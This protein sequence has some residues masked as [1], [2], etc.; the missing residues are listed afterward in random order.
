MMT[1]FSSFLLLEQRYNDEYEIPLYR[2]TLY[3]RTI[4]LC[5]TAYSNYRMSESSIASSDS[6]D[7]FLRDHRSQLLDQ[8]QIPEHLLHDLHRQLLLTFGCTENDSY[9][10]ELSTLSVHEQL[11]SK[12]QWANRNSDMHGSL[13]VLPHAVSWDMKRGQD[14]IEALQSS[15]TKVLHMIW[16]GLEQLNAMECDPIILRGASVNF[17]QKTHLVDAV[18]DHPLFWSRIVLYRCVDG[19]VR[20]AM[21][22]PPFLPQLAIS[23]SNASGLV[24]DNID[25][26]CMGPF[27]FRYRHPILNHSIDLSLLYVSRAGIFQ[28]QEALM[29]GKSFLPT[30]DLVPYYQY[31]NDSRLRTVRYAALLHST[32]VLHS[33]TVESHLTEIFATFV[34]QMHLV[35]QQAV[36]SRQRQ[37]HF[38]LGSFDLT[39]GFDPPNAGISTIL[40]VF[41]DSDDP[42]GLNHPIAGLEANS[43]HFRIVHDMDSADVVFSYQSVFS[44]K[45]TYHSYLRN[46]SHILINQFPYEGAFVQKDHLARELL[47]QH[48]LPRPLW[49]LETYDLDV[50]LAEMV[51]S[52]LSTRA[53]VKSISDSSLSSQLPLWIVKP[54]LGTQSHGH[55]VTR[56]LAHILHLN[57]AMG[58]RRV[59]QWYV[60]HPL[61][62]NGHKIDARIVVLMTSAGELDENGERI[63]M[64]TLFMHKVC[65]F[66][67]AS[68]PH[69]ISTPSSRS[70]YE[71]VLTASHLIDGK[72]RTTADALRK[73][74]THVDTIRKLE[75][76]YPDSFNWENQQLPQIQ[77]MVVELFN[78]MTNSYPQMILSTRSRAV[79]GV[80]VIFQVEDA[81]R[82]CKSPVI[83]PKL[84][85]VT[86][87]PAN[88][89]IC[90]AYVR[91]ENLYRSYNKDIF[92]CLFLGLVSSNI[93]RLQ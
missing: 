2:N 63:K 88:N 42:M 90:E 61:C 15:Q 46:N 13:I 56:S 1:S 50:H 87:C 22:S 6:Y 34:H 84:T 36:E 29:E 3:S 65:Y 26:D 28:M 14:V 10:I 82:S 67:I 89:A 44:P 43:T 66:R 72:D 20:G 48:G 49:A 47:K 30:I 32:R 17:Y 74:P 91:D 80:D 83:T 51:G 31:P 16:K 64:P 37:E 7:I 62:I 38:L 40:N 59:A 92:E 9:N 33:C 53:D 27:P 4:S 24:V 93:L 39:A 81:D 76:D 5:F 85:E 57:D 18:A 54:A 68:K 23:T 78:G 71:S 11:N 55:I 79:Y 52:V 58:G 25:A 19:T 70:D 41:T 75:N 8:L 73:L 69:V 77:T 45:C 60:E 35:R 21:P 86:F 12:H